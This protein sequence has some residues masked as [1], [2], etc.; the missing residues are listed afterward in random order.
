[1]ENVVYILSAWYL[2]VCQ[3]LLDD[4]KP[5]FSMC[6][7]RYRHKGWHCR[8]GQRFPGKISETGAVQPGP[9][10]SHLEGPDPVR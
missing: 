9:D 8:K 3:M 5:L 6:F 4:N 7:L 10:H 2:Q 1:M